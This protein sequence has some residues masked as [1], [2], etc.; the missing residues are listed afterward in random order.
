MG[1][2]R[3]ASIRPVAVAVFALTIN[4]AATRPQ[5]VDIVTLRMEPLDQKLY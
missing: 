2:Q 5:G 1:Y 3:F 4:F